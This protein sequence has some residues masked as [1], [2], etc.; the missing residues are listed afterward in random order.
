MAG[1]WRDNMADDGPQPACVAV[2]VAVAAENLGITQEAVR[3]RM[4]RGTLRGE[5]RGAAWFV[6]LAPDAAG[7]RDVAGHGGTDGGTEPD[8]WRDTAGPPPKP[9]DDHGVLVAQL[10]AENARLAAALERSQQGE[11]EL[12][13]LLAASEQRRLPMPV[14]V[15]TAPEPAENG[16]VGADS[17]SQASRPWWALWRR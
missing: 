8:D 6:L 13:R 7:W 11:A 1:Q 14:D 10:Q 5:K 15:T 3:K 2:P 9:V 12:R 4:R 17:A 16:P